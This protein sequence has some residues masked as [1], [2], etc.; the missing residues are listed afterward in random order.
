MTNK[1]GHYNT[2][3][4]LMNIALKELSNIEVGGITAS[5]T[6]TLIKRNE[7]NPVT[8]HHDQGISQRK[9]NLFCIF[10]GS[11]V[12]RVPEFQWDDCALTLRK[13]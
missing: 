4:L 8:T 12:K 7:D 11:L 1:A 13:N 9:P 3:R 2:L 10:H 5:L 6:D